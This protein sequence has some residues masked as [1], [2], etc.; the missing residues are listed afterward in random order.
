LPVDGS[1]CGSVSSSCM[2]FTSACVVVTACTN[3]V[4]SVPTCGS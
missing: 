4:W 1:P 3:Y 2:Y